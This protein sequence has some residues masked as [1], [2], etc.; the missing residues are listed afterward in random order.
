M[1]PKIKSRTIW[2]LVDGL[3]PLRAFDDKATATMQRDKLGGDHTVYAL[4]YLHRE[5]E[6]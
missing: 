2:V 5:R 6:E 4:P 3:E 1:K